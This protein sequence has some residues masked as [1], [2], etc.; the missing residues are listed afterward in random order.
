MT[1]PVLLIP[2]ALDPTQSFE[3]PPGHRAVD[4][5]LAFWRRLCAPTA[6]RALGA[7]L[8]VP[9][10]GDGIRCLLALAA[11]DALGEPAWSA[12]HLLGLAAAARV[13]GGDDPAL[14]VVV[15][16]IHLTAG[17]T[18]SSA[19]VA[20]AA[21]GSRLML[22]EIERG[23]ALLTT[24]PGA[25]VLLHADQQLP[26]VF[27]MVSRA[28]GVQAT[29]V[30]PFARAHAAALRRVPALAAARVLPAEPGAARARIGGVL[31]ANG[32]TAGGTAWVTRAPES[33]P[34]GPWAG[35]LDAA[36][37]AAL[38][39]GQLARCTGL[40]VTVARL[41]SWA[42]AR[43]A[44]GSPHDLTAV[45]PPLARRVPVALDLLAGAP[46]VPPDH[47]AHVAERATGVRI[48]GCRPFRLAAGPPV[49]RWAGI[50][51]SARPRPDHDLARWA[52][53]PADSAATAA[54][55]LGQLAVRHA[56]FPGR[57]AAA[58]FATDDAP[59]VTGRRV[60]NPAVR[61]VRSTH[62]AP[63]GAAPGDFLV[64]LRTGRM[65]RVGRPMAVLCDA[66]RRGGASAE[67]ALRRLPEARRAALLRTL[68][69]AGVLLTPKGA[70]HAA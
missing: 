47:I 19:D 7:E 69:A 31:G 14:T 25:R 17:S 27:G 43:G 1:G 32:G 39:G 5:N 61:Q 45:L 44:D 64:N 52:E 56:L 13:R 60:W 51:V 30:G 20:R 63:P 49:R 68:T 38:D 16:D 48:A 41:D 34:T 22:P 42:E 40:V 62:A 12:A 53:G 36:D 15:D 28:P 24:E 21:V 3:A 58:L 4:L 54:E 66:L 18:Q 46:G 29:V 70:A 9:E 35:W 65:D 50:P 6:V 57:L 37:A 67:T 33:P 59:R 8:D 11:A 26:A 2:P 55:L 23:A 10:G